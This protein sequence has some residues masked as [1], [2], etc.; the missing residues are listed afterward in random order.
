MP[1]WSSSL[2]YETNFPPRGCAANG[3]NALS[4]FSARKSTLS[5]LRIA[6]VNWICHL[7]QATRCDVLSMPKRKHHSTQ[8]ALILADSSPVIRKWRPTR[9]PRLKK[10]F[11]RARSL[12]PLLECLQRRRGNRECTWAGRVAYLTSGICSR[13]RKRQR[14]QSRGVQY[15]QHR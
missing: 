10:N 5:A 11:Q 14:R 15:L 12:S 6:R 13:R 9:S 1:E 7:G 4:L 3:G 2:A 8:P